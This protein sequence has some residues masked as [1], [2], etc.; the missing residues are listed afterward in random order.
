LPWSNKVDFKGPPLSSLVTVWAELSLL[1]QITLVPTG[2]VIVS[3]AY[4]KSAIFISITLAE[5]AAAVVVAGAAVVMAAIVAAAVVVVVAGVVIA[6]IV[7]AALVVIAVVI[8]LIEVPGDITI[9]A[10]VGAAAGT[11]T[12]VAVLSPQAASNSDKSSTNPRKLYFLPGFIF[13]PSIVR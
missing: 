7:I 9:A 3:G 11:G 1:V 10:V 8:A 2:I 6:A 12:V 5:A 4:L 13:V